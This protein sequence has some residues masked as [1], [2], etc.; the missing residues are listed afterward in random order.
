MSELAGQLSQVT[1]TGEKE[2]KGQLMAALEGVGKNSTSTFLVKLSK[3][4]LAMLG[5]GS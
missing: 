3:K 5:E 4:E 2:W 1:T